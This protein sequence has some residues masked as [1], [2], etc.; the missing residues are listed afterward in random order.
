[1]LNVVSVVDVPCPFE[2]F[3]C[4]NRVKDVAADATTNKVG[5]NANVSMDIATVVQEIL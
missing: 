3:V 5:D 2:V 1:M 4:N